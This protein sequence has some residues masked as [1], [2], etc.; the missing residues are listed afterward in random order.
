M[1][2]SFYSCHLQEYRKKGLLI[3]ARSASHPCVLHERFRGTLPINPLGHV[4]GQRSWPSIGLRQTRYSSLALPEISSTNSGLILWETSKRV[5][6]IRSVC[7]GNGVAISTDTTLYY[8]VLIVDC[9]DTVTVHLCIVLVQDSVRLAVAGA[10]S[11]R[12][13]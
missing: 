5:A 9:A 1:H 6:V 12:W 8:Q 10:Y 3:V 11:L 2:I 4:G 7:H 13:T